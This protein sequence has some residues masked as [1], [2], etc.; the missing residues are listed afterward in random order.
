M[1][2]LFCDGNDVTW[3]DGLGT[4]HRVRIHNWI[5]YIATCRTFARKRVDKHVSVE[6]DSWK[7]ARYGTH[8]HGYEWSTKI[9]WIA[10]SYIRGRAEQNESSHK[11]DV[12]IGIQS[13]QNRER[14]GH[15]RIQQVR[16][17]SNC[18]LLQLIVIKSDCE[19]GVDKSNHPIQYPLLLVTLA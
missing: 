11:S 7:P 18:D 19:E 14:S 13:E 17:K 6:I 1:I 3:C 16:L 12:H 8:F 10:K 9:P 2:I 5:Y 4:R 15:I